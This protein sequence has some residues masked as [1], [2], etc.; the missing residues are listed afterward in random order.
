MGDQFNNKRLFLGS[1]MALVVTAMTFSIRAKLMPVFGDQFQLNGEELGL[2]A[3]TAFWGFTLAMI[4]GGPLVDIVGMKKI[5]WLAFFSHLIGI[6][7]TIFATGF[8]SL[9]IGTL[10]IGIGNGMVEAACNPLVATLYAN[11]KT[12]KLNH[13][14][15]WFPGGNVIGGIIAYFV[16]DQL[17]LSWEL[18]MASMFLPLAIYGFIFLGQKMPETERVTS[19][20]STGSMFKASLSPLFIFMV[21]CMFLTAATELAT[22]QWIEALL[23]QVGVSAILLFVFINGIMMIGRTFAGPVVH[24]LNP[25]GMLLFSAIFAAIGLFWLSNVSGYMAFAAATVFAVGVCYFWPTMLGFV[26]E[27]VPKSGALGLSI[28]GG[29]GMLS[30]SLV[31]PIIGNVY[32]ANVADAVASGLD[33]A[34]A[35]LQG[36]TTTLGYVAFIPVFLIVAFTGLY[37]YSKN[38]KRNE[39]TENPA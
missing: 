12:K 15:I 34:T 26:A 35:Q 11:E 10:I 30:V 3:G 22:T 2:V 21:V 23:G 5:V 6:L 9:F 14:H 31:L 20:V 27:Y 8:W 24:K 25:A 1:C 16:I 28:M 29:A 36:G 37:F 39:L 13:F 19:G 17:N 7:V 33:E 18:L 32:D 38:K 4:F